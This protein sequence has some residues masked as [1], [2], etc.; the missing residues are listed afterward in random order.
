MAK[1]IIFIAVDRLHVEILKAETVRLSE[2]VPGLKVIKQ[3]PGS[4][5]TNV[6]FS[7]GRNIF[8]CSP[9]KAINLCENGK[10]YLIK[11]LLSVSVFDSDTLLVNRLWLKIKRLF[12]WIPTD[13]HVNFVSNSICE[14]MKMNIKQ[15]INYTSPNTKKHILNDYDN[16]KFWW[17]SCGERYYRLPMLNQLCKMNPYGQG[18][19]F[20]DTAYQAVH[21]K[22]SLES[23]SNFKC[24]ILHSFSMKEI[25]D[26]IHSYNNGSI[27]YIIAHEYKSPIYMLH[28]LDPL[29]IIIDFEIWNP[30]SYLK[31]ANIGKYIS[32]KKIH[33]ISIMD[34]NQ[35]Q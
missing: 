10:N 14:E 29:Q 23:R 12:K 24:K 28:Q 19:I 11:K 30:S 4:S 33:I 35:T 9:G 31:R 13:I 26:I 17:V 5:W 18:V 22:H 16:L 20:C 3:I 15:L 7:E 27:Q 21:I 1:H 32:K 8:I 25:N 34:R 2:Y 6:Q